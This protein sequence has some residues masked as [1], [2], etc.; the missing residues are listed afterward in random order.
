[1]SHTSRAIVAVVLYAA[2]FALRG[3]A[4]QPEPAVETAAVSAAQ[5]SPP[6]ADLHSGSAQVVVD[7]RP[8]MRL[9]TVPGVI[10]GEQRAAEATTRIL[11]LAEQ[12]ETR[13]DIRPAR[14]DGGIALV[15]GDRFLV[16]LYPQDATLAGLPLTELA[17]RDA[18][19]L[20]AAIEA[21]RNAR[22]LRTIARRAGLAALAWLAFIVLVRILRHASDA[23]RNRIRTWRI[24]G[25]DRSRVR[26]LGKQLANQIALLVFALARLVIAVVLLVLFLN[27]VTLTLRVFPQ[28]G[29]L[30]DSVLASE[31]SAL[32]S[33]L[34][35]IVD[36]LPSL[37]FL[38]VI[39]AVTVY[40]LK[41]LRLLFDALEQRDLNF[42]GFLSEWSSP[43][44]SIVRFLVIVFAV[45]VAF[46]HLPGGESDAFKG[47]SIFFGVLF[48]L[49]STS[50][51]SNVVSGVILTYM[52]PYRVGDFVEIG[53]TAGTVI[54]RDFLVTRIRTIKNEEVT[55]PNSSVLGGQMKNY[56][57]LAQDRGL[58]VHTA[59]TIGYDAPWRKVHE[60][61]IA[62][63]KETSGVADEP[64]PFVWQTSLNDYHV[65]YEINAFTRSPHELFRIQADLHRNI[66]DAFNEAGVEIMS[67]SFAALRDGNS[68]TL[69]RSHR[70]EGYKAPSFRFDRSPNAKS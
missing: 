59:I 57:A 65:S 8:V 25:L 28:S 47:V 41:A 44:Y 36:Y 2:C 60:L 40:I 22:S 5:P 53:G 6:K 42:E 48:S 68:I 52:H 37:V 31:R 1:M 69:P 62:A 20:R 33:A 64:F 39:V 34:L 32:E 67:P 24:G 9:A 10:S 30:A 7:G 27:L 17:K 16:S 56:S 58:I 29:S 66:Q 19:A 38:L 3:E 15:D 51:V 12:G 4:E 21:H 45:V 18:E 55:I 43:T 50:T 26:R 63:A 14:H 13:S 11:E 46:P 70:P 23:V 35:A 61:M 54:R 49:G